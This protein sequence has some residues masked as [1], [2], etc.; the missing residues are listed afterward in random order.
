MNNLKNKYTQRYSIG[1]NRDN[2][3]YLNSITK[4]IDEKHPTK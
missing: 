3:R 2:G 4:T 1:T